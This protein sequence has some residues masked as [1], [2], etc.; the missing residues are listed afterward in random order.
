MRLLILGCNGMAGHVIS[1]YLK[2]QGHCV[3]GF[4]RENSEFIQTVIGDARDLGLLNRTIRDGKYDAVINCIGVL[5]EFAETDREAAVFLNSYL[6]HY[7]ARI[8]EKMTAR[9]V[10]ISTDCVFSGKHGPYTEYALRDSRTFYGRSKSLGELEDKKNITLRSS[11]V[12][13][14]RKESGIGLLNWFMKQKESVRGYKNVIWTGQ[15]TLQ[16]AKTIEML[17]KTE[18]GGLYN[19]APDT[20]I[21]K[22]DLLCLFNRE[23]RKHPI[24]IIPFAEIESNKS[25]VCTR[26]SELDFEIPGYAFMIKELSRWMQEHKN[27]YPHYEL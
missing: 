2:E 16:L 14:D 17:L 20:C 4:A 12:G 8:T 23:I 7:L 6:P 27:L 21:S 26:H 25:L 18:T 22:Y 13:P 24:E 5:N 9:I 19:M 10:Q 3:T 11:I 15:T 1:L